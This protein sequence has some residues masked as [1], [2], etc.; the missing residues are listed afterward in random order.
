[1]EFDRFDVFEIAEDTPNGQQPDDFFFRKENIIN[2]SKEKR[3]DFY[4]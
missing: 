1:M 4:L 2:N 3:W